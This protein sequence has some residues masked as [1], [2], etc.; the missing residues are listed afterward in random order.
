MICIC[1]KQRMARE[2]L[3]LIMVR[4]KRSMAATEDVWRIAPKLGDYEWLTAIKSA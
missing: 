2:E 3:R 4:K 1:S